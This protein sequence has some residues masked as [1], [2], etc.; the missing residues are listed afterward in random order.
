MMTT[1]AL[2]LNVTPKQ[3]TTEDR[4]L[5][6][7]RPQLSDNSNDNVIEDFHRA[8]S[9]HGDYDKQGLNEGPSDASTLSLVA[10]RVA[11]GPT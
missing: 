3:I 8:Q 1:L 7:N 2:H 9:N 6:T 10:N 4:A 5:T 11:N